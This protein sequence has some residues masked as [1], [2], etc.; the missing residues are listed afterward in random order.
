MGLLPH[1]NRYG[2]YTFD[3]EKLAD[4]PHTIKA[5]SLHLGHK[6]VATTMFSYGHIPERQQME[7]L[8]Y[9]DFRGIT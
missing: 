7:I 6:H 5:L 9:L 4:N 3:L 1:I 8:K 2:R